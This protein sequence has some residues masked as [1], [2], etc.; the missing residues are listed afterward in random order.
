MGIKN[1][2]AV[3]YINCHRRRS[4]LMVRLE[5]SIFEEV[6]KKVNSIGS[7]PYNRKKVSYQN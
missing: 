1:Y 5:S 3:D 4:V 6:D 7:V 2:E